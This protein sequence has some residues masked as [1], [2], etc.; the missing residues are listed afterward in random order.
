MISIFHNQKFLS[1]EMTKKINSDDLVL[2]AEVDTDD[3]EEAYK[4]TNHI[5]C[6][7]S[8]NKKVKTIQRSRST[9][10]GDV[11]IYNNQRY[12]VAMFGFEKIS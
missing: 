3:L 9:S 8:N 7:W 1:Y 2:V 11:L 10:M 12:V 5:D 4:L 6:N